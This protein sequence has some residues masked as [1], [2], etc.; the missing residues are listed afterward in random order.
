MNFVNISEIAVAVVLADIAF[1]V[2]KAAWIA[3]W[4]NMDKVN[5]EYRR[6]PKW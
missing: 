1:A 2:L 3:L 5:E 6:H 4:E